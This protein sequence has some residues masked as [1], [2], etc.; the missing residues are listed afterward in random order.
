LKPMKT[1]RRLLPLMTLLLSGA[2]SGCITT[3]DPEDPNSGGAGGATATGGTAAGGTTG[4]GGTGGDGSGG[5]GSGGDGSGGATPCNVCS[6][7]ANA[8][9][10]ATVANT[11]AQN[12]DCMSVYSCTNG[13]TD[14]PTYAACLQNCK[15]QYPAGVADFTAYV[16]CLI[17]TEC[18][19]PCQGHDFCTL[20]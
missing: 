4:T 7:Q 2:V 5:D 18:I 1:N 6:A 15:T 3:S 16:T 17:C 10:C 20:W 8:G 19:D 9:P 13:C 11:C 14:P 12:A